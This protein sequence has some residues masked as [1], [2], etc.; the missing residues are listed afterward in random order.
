M[1]ETKS[2]LI[3]QITVSELFG[4][5]TYDLDFSSGLSGD[6][7][8]SILYGA[9]ASGKTTLLRLIY[10]AL[11]REDRKGIKSYLAETPFKRLDIRLTDGSKVS[12]TKPKLTGSFEMAITFADG[13]E[14]IH[15]LTADSDNLI[16]G[17]DNPSFDRLLSDLAD[18]KLDLFHITDKREYFTTIE[19][20][21][22]HRS[23]RNRLTEDDAVFAQ[24]ML[25]VRDREGETFR[26]EDIAPVIRDL[27]R[28]QILERGNVGQQSSNTIY[29]DLALAVVGQSD[30]RPEITSKADLLKTV[31]RLETEIEPAVKIE[32]IPHVPFASFLSA[33]DKATKENIGA[34]SQVLSPFLTS[35]EARFDAIK[36]D[37]LRINSFLDE[38][39]RFYTGKRFFFSVGRGFYIKG[40]AGAPREIPMDWLSSGERQLF[41]ILASVFLT[42]QSTGIVL[43]DEPELSLNT[44][45]QRDFVRA[46]QRIGADTSVQ[47]VLATHSMEIMANQERRV[48]TLRREIDGGNPPKARQ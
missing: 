38:I 11:S 41:T 35:L 16:K 9:N 30:A 2:P 42:Q 44:L 36:P 32:A 1:T 17:T 39:N 13:R 47:Y 28:T 10:N 48:I 43:I 23:R 40:D 25:R 34:L 6:G 46:L 15:P 18:L 22:P 27:F 29:L 26:V 20:L 7:N 8:I 21:R 31:H 12:I 4:Q 45:W 37:V 19:Q 3:S 24:Y 5:Y 14:R 33:I